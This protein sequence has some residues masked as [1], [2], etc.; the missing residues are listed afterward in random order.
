[1]IVFLQVE[2]PGFAVLKV[3]ELEYDEEGKI[4]TIKGSA[5]E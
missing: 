3:V 4:Q 1:M 5:D 2:R